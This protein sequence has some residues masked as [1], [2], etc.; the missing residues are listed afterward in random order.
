[1]ATSK[2]VLERSFVDAKFLLCSLSG[3]SDCCYRAQ[4]RA[5]GAAGADRPR[6]EGRTD[7]DRRLGR[8]GPRHFRASPCSLSSACVQLRWCA[9]PLQRTISSV[10]SVSLPVLKQTSDL[11]RLEGQAEAAVLTAPCQRDAVDTL[12]SARLPLPRVLL[13]RDVDEGLALGN[14]TLGAAFV[15]GLSRQRRWSRDQWLKTLDLAIAIPAAILSLPVIGVLLIAVSLPRAAS[16]TS[17]CRRY[18]T[19]TTRATD[20]S[21]STSCLRPCLPC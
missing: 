7:L 12:C 15:F 14:R 19:S 17:R 11:Y 16:A 18:S 6:L 2:A 9:R 3:I 1:M 4:C 13:L 21:G 10:S 5:P 8:E 20:R